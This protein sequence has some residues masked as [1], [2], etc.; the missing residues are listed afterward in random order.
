MPTF[1]PSVALHAKVATCFA[2]AN[3]T[4]ANTAVRNTFMALPAYALTAERI[5]EISMALGGREFML[6][7]KNDPST[8]L[9]KALAVLVRKGV[10]RSRADNGK[11]LY[12]V[13]Y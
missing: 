11:R 7:L 3:V 9:R 5:I 4:A 2:F 8:E 12:E 1:D 6:L 10:L 13:N